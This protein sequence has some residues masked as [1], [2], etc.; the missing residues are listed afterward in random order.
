MTEKIL[1]CDQGVLHS[2]AVLIDRARSSSPVLRLR[3]SSGVAQNP[4]IGPREY[5]AALAYRP[6]MIVKLV[7][8]GGYVPQLRQKW[9]IRI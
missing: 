3:S 2:T 5:D 7:M 1:R 4:W 9:R 6:V 8:S